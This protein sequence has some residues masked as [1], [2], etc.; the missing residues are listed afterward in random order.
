M[1]PRAN[2][3]KSVPK[4]QIAKWRKRMGFSQKEAAAWLNVP[5]RTYQNWEHGRP[6][7]FP[8][9]LR[10]QMDRKPDDAAKPTGKKKLG[11]SPA[12]LSLMEDE[13]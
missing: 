4:G 6:Q 5:K 1:P 8:D 3:S 11:V 9:W 2:T 12:Q 7:A 13:R 10:Q